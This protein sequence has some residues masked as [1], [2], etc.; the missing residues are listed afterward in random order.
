MQLS[1]TRKK[2]KIYDQYGAEAANQAD[3]MGDDHPM[4]GGMPFGFRPAGGGGGGG[5]HHMSPEEAQAFFSHFFG[6]SDPFGG[7]FG[8]M[9]GPGIH[10]SMGG[11]GPRGG[12]GGMGADPFGSMFG[13]GGMGGMPVGG[14]GGMGG[15][16]GHP[17]FQRVSSQR[18][19]RYDA[20]PPGT[21]V[22]LK[23]LISRPDR[24]GDRGEV[25][26]FDPNSGRYIIV[27]EDTDETMSVKPSN[28]LQH[29]HVKI[30]GLESR[31]DLNG[32]R[33][34]ILA[35]DE[36]KHRYNVYVMSE[37]RVMSLKPANIIL[38]EG[39]VAQISGL[40]AKPE[41][42]GKWG[43]I[44]S[45]SRDTGRYDVQLTADKIVRLKNENMRV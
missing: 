25:Q 41:L 5:A 20:I 34:T 29:V 27:L 18:Q 39:T 14:M 22:S 19:K 17:G 36:G 1:Q 23:G 10:F 31:P 16:G 2:R 3:Q 28:L 9:G 45:W 13:M 26:Q 4:S 15:M 30:H 44:K 6:G 24:N 35:W 43:T 8:G 37:S 21:V 38:E 32:Q 42:N 12:M 11:N 40:M 7:S 33:G